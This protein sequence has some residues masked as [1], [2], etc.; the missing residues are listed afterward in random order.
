MLIETRPERELPADRAAQRLRLVRQAWPDATEAGH[1]PALH[2]VSMLLVDDEIVLA[3]LD[4]LSKQLEHRGRT[5]RASGL[6]AV[7]TDQRSRH[8]GY[9]AA[10][11]K[12]ARL[13]LQNLR[14]DLAVF[15]C[16]SYLSEF[17]VNA[18]FQVLPGAVLI[19]GT[20][21]EPL[22][23]DALD[24]V[25]LGAFFSPLALA[26]R[27]DFVNADIELYPGPIDRLW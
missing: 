13:S 11:V 21:P 15:T 14:R 9:G 24:K 2:P 12:A 23:S 3:S 22:R 7:V 16:D 8:R 1:D 27:A 19:G 26:H 4:I 17:Y 10:L 25:S 5:Y 6:S 18:G 20:R